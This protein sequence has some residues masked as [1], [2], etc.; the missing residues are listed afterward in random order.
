MRYRAVFFFFFEVKLLGLED[1][2]SGPPP[3]PNNS[4]TPASWEKLLPGPNTS[5]KKLKA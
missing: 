3:P 5:V 1:S 4:R 2:Q